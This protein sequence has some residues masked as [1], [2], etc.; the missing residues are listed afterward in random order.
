MHRWAINQFS[1]LRWAFDEDIRRY[2]EEGFRAVGISRVKLGDFGEEKAAE[3]LADYRFTVTSLHWVGGF[4][5]CDDRSFKDALADGRRALR[6]AQEIG[7]Q[8]VVV[9]SGSQ[10]GHILNHAKRLLR[11]ALRGLLPLAEEFGVTLL[12]EPIPLRCA[13]PWTFLRS[14]DQAIAFVDDLGS[15]YVRLVLDLYYH[16]HCQPLMEQID[17]VVPYLGLVQIADTCRPPVGHTYR[18]PPGM[19]TIPLERWVD[20]LA[21]EGYEGWFEFEVWGC[22]RDGWGYVDVLRC[23]RE[24]A[25]LW[26]RYE[27]LSHSTRSSSSG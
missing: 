16:G 11:D 25:Q 17:G 2:H 13:D 14:F 5:G 20:R 23:C 12:L 3:L 22:Q 26:S 8:N 6:T 7:A 18:C 10:G 27:P 21:D 1:T 9:H 4:T 24:A 15:P 19:G